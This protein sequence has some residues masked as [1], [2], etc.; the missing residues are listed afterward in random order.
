LTMIACQLPTLF[1]KKSKQQNST[2][3]VSQVD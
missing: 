1:K 2:A 3:L